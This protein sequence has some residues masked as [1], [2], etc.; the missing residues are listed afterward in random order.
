MWSWMRKSTLPALVLALAIATTGAAA[1]S[2]GAQT[3]RDQIAL[4]DREYA[5]RNAQSA[6]DFYTKALSLE[7]KNYEALWKASLAETDLAELAPKGALQD[8]LLNVATVHAAAAIG[9]NPHDAEGHFCAARVAGRKA[10]TLGTRDRIK[11]AKI[12][13]LEAL[14]A[15]KADS[16]HPGALDVLGMWNAEIMRINGLARAFAKAFLGADIFALAS[17]DEAQRLLELAVKGDPARIVHRL[18]LAGIYAD[19]GDKARA[20]E[21]YEIIAKAPLHDATDPLYKQQ[22]AERL[23]KL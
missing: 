13:R 14:D 19:R 11:Y 12:V 17:W 18:D 7:A 1:H 23:R 15:L 10:L 3:A 8:S 21:Q 20:R 9:V 16:L 5:A 4:G 22:A 2:L 6:L